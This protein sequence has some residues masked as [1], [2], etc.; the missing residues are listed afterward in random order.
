VACQRM[1]DRETFIVG[2][3][4]VIIHIERREGNIPG[5]SLQMLEVEQ[6]DNSITS[7]KNNKV[8]NGIE[9]NE[10]NAPIAYHF[11][12]EGIDTYSKTSTR[13]PAERVI[14]YFRHDRIRQLLGITQLVASL[15]KGNHLN[16]YDAY[17]LLAARMEASMTATL[18][19][20]PTF[21]SGDTDG[22]GLVAA[23]GDDG[24]TSVGDT[25]IILEP[26]V[27]NKLP[28]G[29]QLEF[30]DPRRPNK[31][32]AEY[33]DEQISQY[34]AGMGL[35]FSL[36]K[37]DYSKGNFSS[38]RQALI[39]LNKSI[40]A[41]QQDFIE[42]FLQPIRN[43]FTK[44]CVLQGLLEAPNFE[45]PEWQESYLEDKWIKPARPWIDPAKA[46]AANLI[47]LETGSTTLAEIAESQGKD[48][49]ELLLQRKAEA[50]FAES[51]DLRLPWI[52]TVGE[53]TPEQDKDREEFS[54][55]NRAN[56]LKLAAENIG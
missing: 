16:M 27:V 47:E 42:N 21:D 17:E 22:I 48:W 45:D 32:Y 15:V 1:G 8:V 34:A 41:I 29:Q 54:A 24:L 20:D 5:L 46:A 53:S 12:T 39:E 25:E 51:L 6:L 28:I 19:Y 31:S 49:R 35:D 30:H 3:A 44:V 40:D 43:W 33:M 4:F 52:A 9:T 56:I 7:Y 26:G 2:N 13:V 38:Q 11:F 36:I 14:H 23:D 55:A 37:R 18:S 10:R 50:D